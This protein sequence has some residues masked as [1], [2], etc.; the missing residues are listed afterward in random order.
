MGF[1]W[2]WMLWKS[3]QVDQWR[4]PES[5]G[6]EAIPMSPPF[7]FA[8]FNDFFFFSCSSVRLL[9]SMSYDLACC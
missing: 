3:A 6:M 9:C 2:Y 5:P 4:F 7:A 8:A 1:L